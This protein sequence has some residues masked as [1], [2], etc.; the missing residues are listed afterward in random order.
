MENFLN[1]FLDVRW[2]DIVDITLISYI[3]FRL[4]VLFRGTNAFRVLIGLALLWFFQG[5]AVFLG[6]VL[7]S[8]AIQGIMAVAAIIIIVVFRNEIRNVL[9]AKNL[10]AIIWGFSHRPVNTPIE[11]IVDSIFDLSRRKSGALLVFPGENDLRDVAHSGIPWRG[12]VSKEMILSIFWHDNPV[13][14]GAAI[15]RDDRITEVGVILPLSFRNDF[16]SSY[17]TRHRAAVGLAEKTDALSIMV[18]EESGNVLAVKDSEV[19]HIRDKRDLALILQKHVGITEKQGGYQKRE[20][21]EVGIAALVCVLLVT[22]VWHSFSRGLESLTSLEIQIEYMNRDP[23]MEILDTSIN[24]VNLRLSGSGALIKSIR[25]EQIKVTL[26][27]SKAV[28]GDNSFT[29]TNEN[30]SHPPGIFLRD[31][32]PQAVSVMLDI[33]SKKEL[34]IQVDWVGK[35]PEH[36]IITSARLDP[37]KIEVIG[38]SRILE[39]IS[40]IY[41]EKVPLDTI[42]TT[43]PIRARLALN[44]ASLK[45]APGSQEEILVEVM[46]GRRN[47]V[48]QSTPKG[49]DPESQSKESGP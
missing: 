21:L 33:L 40:T 28:I 45:I 7:T 10:K 18:S 25:P 17:G 31:I 8:W 20:K 27:L 13:H 35:S 42:K 36:L 19:K 49:G 9:Q 2:Q 38:G 24:A 29:I 37:D 41:T 23:R 47:R 1:S 43:G 15:I 16:P 34:P 44:P 11:V 46:T 30:V 14:D 26:D 48:K 5:I 32:K 12:L 39:D 3:I 22:S 4:Y 6:L